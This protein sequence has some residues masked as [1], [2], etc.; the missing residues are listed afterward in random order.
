MIYLEF[1]PTDKTIGK[2]NEHLKL[3][4]RQNNSEGIPAIGFN[5]GDKLSAIQQP[6]EAVYTISEKE[7]NGKVDLQL[8]LKDLR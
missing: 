4:V 1:S 6:F 8:M 3:F 2:E 5:L 7:Y